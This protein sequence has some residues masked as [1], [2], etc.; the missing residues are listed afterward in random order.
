MK[1]STL[2]RRRVRRDEQGAALI[3]AI[4]FM[5]VAG[6]LSAAILPHLR[7]SALDRSVLDQVRN[8]QYDADYAIERSIAR[9]RAVTP[10]PG[11]NPN[12]C[13]ASGDI[14]TGPNG[15]QI[16]VNCANSPS[17]S[18]SGD[19][20][21]ASQANVTFVACVNAGT[22]CNAVRTSP[23]YNVI[24]SAQVNFQTVGGVVQTFVQAWSV[25]R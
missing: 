19:G 3:L 23:T 17:V 22:V 16:R 18:P 20:T 24:V 13:P 25:N 15:N 14:W 8:R 1:L 10:N 12:E 21:P 9:V 2:V 6:L 5:L 4:A 11:T 7:S